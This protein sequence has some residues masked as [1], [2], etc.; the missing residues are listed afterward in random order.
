MVFCE[1]R[2]SS[3]RAD[4]KV[5]S[6]SASD[7]WAGVTCLDWLDCWGEYGAC[8]VGAGGPDASWPKSSNDEDAAFEEAELCSLLNGDD[9]LDPPD[10]IAANGSDGLGVGV[11][12]EGIDGDFAREADEE[13][14][15]VVSSSAVRVDGSMEVITHLQLVLEGVQHFP[16]P[17]VRLGRKGPVSHPQAW[18]QQGD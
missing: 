14:S 16:G 8:R 1:G 13:P 17:E 5:H 3:G 15:S 6:S 4:E 9:V 12:V 11:E 10:V 18:K 2:V 7:V